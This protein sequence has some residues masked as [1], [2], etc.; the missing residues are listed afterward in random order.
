MDA[1]PKSNKLKRLEKKRKLELRAQKRA[2]ERASALAASQLDRAERAFRAA[3]AVR[4]D[5]P[6]FLERLAGG[7][8]PGDLLSPELNQLAHLFETINRR[9]P[10]G[11]PL[12]P[13]ADSFR[14]LV[15][16]C[17]DRT[18]LLRGHEMRT[19]ANALLALSAHHK[20]WQRRPGNWEPR[21]HNSYRQFHS[22][23]RHL[24]ALYDVPMF[25]NSA[26]IE[27][28][29][30]LGVL[31]Q[32]WFIRLA[33]G[34]S[35]RTAPGLP[36]PLTR[37]QAHLYLQAPDDFDVL[38]AFRWAQILDLGG[39]EALVHSILTTRIG[40]TFEHDEFW[41]TVFRWLIE[42]PM[43]DPVHHGPIIDFLHH[44]RFVAS[45]PNP[46]A[47][48]PG[49]PLLVPPQA[50]LSMK[51]RSAEG[52][53]RAVADWHR[54]LGRPTRREPRYW[55][56]NGTFTPFQ[57]EEGRGDSRRVYTI[58]ELLS[59][60][61]LEAE[62][63]AMAHCVASYAASCVQGQVSIWSL[64][65]VD[66][67]GRQSRLLTLEVSTSSREIVQARQRFN[68]LPDKR[69]LAI[70]RRWTAAGGPMLSKWVAR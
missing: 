27:G 45:M 44:Q 49:Q 60:A 17:W 19:F 54:T 43:L 22:L 31:H 40:R 8:Q 34:G 18:D 15:E 24:L 53:L 42:Q 30:H 20:V 4:R 55:A 38:S 58:T 59:S 29:T 21:F 61:E 35:L 70:L 28:L 33:Q 67:W 10:C 56:P 9:K 48:L 57:L 25:M 41:V 37:R 63:K 39:D 52:L 3:K 23:V 7:E 13:D 26:W 46:R 6:R 68:A 65:V 64:H 69:S 2:E 14:R 32:K 11:Y 50:N 5:I 36:I 66:A 16:V 47:G 1:K 51:G 62:G 12:A